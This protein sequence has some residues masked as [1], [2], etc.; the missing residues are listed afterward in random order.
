MKLSFSLM[1]ISLCVVAS[2][3]M[4]KISLGGRPIPLG[5]HEGL[6]TSLSDKP[7]ISI[8]YSLF[9]KI[10]ENGER[11]KERNILDIREK[12]EKKWFLITTKMIHLSLR[13]IGYRLLPGLQTKSVYMSGEKPVY[14]LQDGTQ[15][16][17][18]LAQILD[19]LGILN[20]Y[21]DPTNKKI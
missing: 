14:L 2:Y 19:A 17:G 8:K 20:H 5:L 11:I 12:K 13:D 9:N 18:E 16:E 7:C 10:I 6:A 21:Y 3:S 1:L 15:I 4:E